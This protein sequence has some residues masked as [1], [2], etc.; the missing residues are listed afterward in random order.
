MFPISHLLSPISCLLS[1]I[2]R[3]LSPISRLLSPVSRLLSHISCA[4][5]AADLAELRNHSSDFWANCLFFAQKWANE[6][7]AQKN[8]LF[9]HSLIFG[10]QPERFAH[11]RS[12]PLR[13]L[14]ESLMVAHFWWAIWTNCSW[15]LIS[16]EGPVQM[17]HGGSF[18]V[19]D[20]NESLTVAH[21]IFAEMREMS[22]WA[23]E[24]WENERV[25][26]PEI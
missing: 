23:N 17:A 13:D 20:L 8:E 6:R 7:F 25:P 9:T 15:S 1:P 3:L 14:S 4:V 19:R 24:R 10:E 21:L 12:F 11:D 22:E 5:T 18:L 2:F 26:S 16:S